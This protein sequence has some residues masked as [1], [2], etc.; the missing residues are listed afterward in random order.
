MLQLLKCRVFA[1]LAEFFYDN[2][3]DKKAFR[4]LVKVLGL[5]PLV[6]VLYWYKSRFWVVFLFQVFDENIRRIT[7]RIVAS[8]ENLLPFEKLCRELCERYRVPVP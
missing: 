5:P 3:M 6:P 4:D 7:H 2:I 1:D 8:H